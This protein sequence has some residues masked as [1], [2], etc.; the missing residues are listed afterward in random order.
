MRAIV[1]NAIIKSLLESWVYREEER[2]V[3]QLLKA[4]LDG[5]KEAVEYSERGHGVC[6]FSSLSETYVLQTKSFIFFFSALVDSS[7]F[8]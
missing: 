1:G 5:F 4:Y 6:D 2:E 8:Q 7:H 3:L